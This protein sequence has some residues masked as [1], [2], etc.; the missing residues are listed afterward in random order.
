M[1]WMRTVD[2]GYDF[3]TGTLSQKFSLLTC[4]AGAMFVL[5]VSIGV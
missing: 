3:P 4:V 5:V 2:D 1:D